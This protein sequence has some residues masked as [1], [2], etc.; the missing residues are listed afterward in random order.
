MASTKYTV[1][2]IPTPPRRQD[3][4][5]AL[6]ANLNQIQDQLGDGWDFVSMTEGNGPDIFHTVWKTV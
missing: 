5:F 4:G 3:V 1:V 2:T 6:E